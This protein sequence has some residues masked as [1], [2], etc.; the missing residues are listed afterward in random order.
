[1]HARR[2]PM[3]PVSAWPPSWL[4][5]TRATRVRR[6]VWQLGLALA[7]EC[8]SAPSKFSRVLQIARLKGTAAGS[9]STDR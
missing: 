9:R 4:P 8:R 5:A 6:A 3:I 1:V 7:R 2:A